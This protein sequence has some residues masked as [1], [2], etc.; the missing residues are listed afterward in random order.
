M[1]NKQ[2]FTLIELLYPA[3]ISRIETLRDDEARCSGFTLIELLVVVLIIGILAAVAVPQYQKAV[4]KSRATQL[5]TSVKSLADAQELYHMSSGNWATS[6]DDLDIS[7]DNMPQVT[8][9]S[10]DTPATES[11]NAKRGTNHMDLIL[12]VDLHTE[13]S[14]FV[15]SRGQFHDGPYAPAGF[16]YMHQNTGN[17]PSG[18]YCT[19]INGRLTG[20]CHNVMGLN[21]NSD[22]Y[23][24][25]IHYYKLK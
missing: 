6:F 23:F 10:G 15:V 13:G 11:T 14:N 16:S 17:V 9:E 25:S 7:F 5:M 24:R 18:L 1:K 2:A 3:P 8:I 21:A 12:N 4:W 22:Y 20:F 19:E